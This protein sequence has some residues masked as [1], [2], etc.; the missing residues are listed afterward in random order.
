MAPMVMQIYAENRELAL[1]TAIGLSKK[2]GTIDKDGMYPR[3]PDGTRMQFIAAHVYMYLDMQG[4]ST[5]AS[6]FQQQVLFQQHKIIAQI[7][8]GREICAYTGSGWNG[9]ND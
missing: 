3:M 2:Y 9:H 1:R 5:A 4:R 7:R 6:L 8:W